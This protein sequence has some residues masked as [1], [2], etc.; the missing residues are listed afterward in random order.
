MEVLNEAGYV[1]V[2]PLYWHKFGQTA[3]SSTKVQITRAVEV[4]VVARKQREGISAYCD[5]PVNPEHRHNFLQG[6]PNRKY[7]MDASG[8]KVN[9]TQKPH[10][11]MQWIAKRFATPGLPILIVGTGAGGEVAA[12][13]EMGVSVVGVEQDLRQVKALHN[14]LIT[15]EA[16][17]RQKAEAAD[18]KFMIACSNQ[19]KKEA[20]AMHIRGQAAIANAPVLVATGPVAESSPSP[21]PAPAAA[22]AISNAPASPVPAAVA[23]E[24][25][26][27][28]ASVAS[29]EPAGEPEKEAA[30]GE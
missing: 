4:I 28:P 29:V 14:S 3:T 30:V 17:A 11:V 27:G 21:P 15:Y 26:P 10:Y 23:E 7:L 13:I 25:N 19:N 1:Y 5:L 22:V 18:E 6:P 8:N 2:D 9:P 20:A 16:G 12:C 24:A